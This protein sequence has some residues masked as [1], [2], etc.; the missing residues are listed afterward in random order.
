MAD[1]ADMANDN[2][3]TEE[4]LRRLAIASK[5]TLKK[6]GK[7]Y[8]CEESFLTKPEEAKLKKQVTDTNIE[9]PKFET[10]S[11]KLFCDCDCEKDYTKRMRFRQPT[12]N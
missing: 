5:P 7:C 2:I 6:I 4:R 3:E 12:L 11:K 9:I 8:N 1:E 10:E